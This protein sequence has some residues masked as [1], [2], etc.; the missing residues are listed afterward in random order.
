MKKTAI[1][2]ARIIDGKGASPIEKGTILICDTKIEAV[3]SIE[4]IHIPEDC[5]IMKLENHTV[6]PALIDGHVHVTGEPGPMDHMGHI[7]G[8]LSAVCKLQ[9]YLKWGIGTVAHAA[10]SADYVP[11]RDYIKSGMLEGC[12]DLLLSGAVTA[13]GGHVRG[14]SADGP[15]EV[16]K[17]VREMVRDGLDYIKTCASGGF[18]W[19]HEKLDYEDYTLIEL[20]A[21]VGEAHARGKRVHVHAHA[22]PG[23][24]N[25]INAGCDVILHGVHIDDEALEAIG[26]KGLWYMPTLHITSEIVWKDRKKWPQFITERMERACPV[27]RQGVAKAY[28]MGLK[29]ITGTDGLAPDAIMNELSEMVCCGFTPL[30][31]ITAA[32]GKTAD[33][34]GILGETG[35]LEPGKRADILCVKGNPLDNI[36]VLKSFESI[37]MVMKAGKIAI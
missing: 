13:T 1:T 31:T 37:K 32:T 21:L 25:A 10:S 23:L 16:R 2:G 22:Q 5:E 20:Q 34:L 14:R 27:H 18:Q 3:G 26:E 12:S 35:T 28:K 9:K 30:D 19:E 11:V 17:A 6:L 15:W 7:K 4:T 8:N 24:R 29:I 33:A 36:C